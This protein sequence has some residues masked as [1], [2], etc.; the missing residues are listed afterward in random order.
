MISRERL[1]SIEPFASKGVMGGEMEI[2]EAVTNRYLIAADIRHHVIVTKGDLGRGRSIENLGEVLAFKRFSLAPTETESAQHYRV[3]MYRFPQYGR[4]LEIAV[5]DQKMAE[6]TDLK[7]QRTFKKGSN[8]NPQEAFKDKF[9]GN[10]NHAIKE[11]LKWALLREKLDPRIHF[12]GWYS[13][14]VMNGIT[15]YLVIG[16]ES[17]AGSALVVTSRLFLEAGVNCFNN[18]MYLKGNDHPNFRREV[19]ILLPTLPIDS[20]I[21]GRVHLARK[22]NELVIRKSSE[23]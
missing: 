16:S 17:T 20:W 7:L 2:N 21:R 13:L 11:G 19:N 8:S 3:A 1:F 23:Q 15:G 5:D 12:F 18:Y 9:L 6:D 22:G 14:V 4:V 10:F